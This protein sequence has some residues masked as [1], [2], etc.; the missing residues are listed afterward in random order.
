ML[1][2]CKKCAYPN[3]PTNSIC[4]R[5]GNVIQSDG[6]LIKSTLFWNDLPL[7]TRNEF[8][9]K[10]KESQLKYKE[11][12]AY[13]RSMLIR[14][15]FAGATILGILGFLTGSIIVS[16][17]ILGGLAGWQTNSR[18]GGAYW[19]MIFS[20]AA[21]VVSL[22]FKTIVGISTANYLLNCLQHGGGSYGVGVG[23]GMIFLF[24]VV[25]LLFSLCLGYY[26]GKRIDIRNFDR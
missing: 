10:Y 22:I 2:L 13:C 24:I 25:G 8:E 3:L 4:G 26:F 6:G 15:V 5:C 9:Q 1:L 7:Q 12:L 19:G 20:G 23:A 18:N 14:D 16:D 11:Y 17:I 21:Y